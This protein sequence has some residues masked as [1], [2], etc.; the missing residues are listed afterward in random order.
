VVVTAVWADIAEN[1]WFGEP[2]AAVAEVLGAEAA[3]FARAFGRLGDLTQLKRLHRG[4]GFGR[5]E[6]R[7][8]TDA[9]TVR[10][11]AEHWAFLTSTI[12]HYRRLDASLAAGQTEGV[13]EVLAQRLEPYRHDGEL[14]IPRRIVLVSARL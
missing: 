9:V 1:P 12:D 6:G 2:R 4:A 11:A 5:V 10:S 13:T 3:T 7:L 8:V 14:R